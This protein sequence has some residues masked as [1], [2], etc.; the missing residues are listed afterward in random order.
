MLNAPTSSNLSDE[1]AGL[2]NSL[3]LLHRYLFDVP[4]AAIRD[5]STT[6]N[7]KAKAKGAFMKLMSIAV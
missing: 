7:E 4:T 2:N 6:A 1:A 3:G 5:H